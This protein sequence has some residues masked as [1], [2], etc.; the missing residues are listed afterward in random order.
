MK[1]LLYSVVLSLL[2]C[3]Q[4]FGANFYW[5]SSLAELN[6]I[7]GVSNSDKAIVMDANHNFIP[8]DHLSGEWRV[9][10]IGSKVDPQA[11]GFLPTAT[12]AV[13]REALQAAINYASPANKAIY[14]SEPGTYSVDQT[15]IIYLS[16]THIIGAGRDKVF[17]VQTG[18]DN[19]AQ[20]IFATPDVI[21]RIDNV[22]FEGFTLRG[23]ELGGQSG[24]LILAD[25]VND[26]RVE[27]M[28]FEKWS[29]MAIHINGTSEASVGLDCYNIKIKNNDFIGRSAWVPGGGVQIYTADSPEVS[30]N[31][32]DYVSR[33]I[34]FE[35]GASAT[36]V[37]N[38]AKVIMNHVS[39]GATANMSA[40]NKYFGILFASDPPSTIHGG[41]VAL[42]TFDTN[43]TDNIVGSADIF[44]D[45]AD[46]KGMVVGFNNHANG[47]GYGVIVTSATGITISNNTYTN[48]DATK[49]TYGINI[50]GLPNQ[51]TAEHN[52]FI[53][54]FV[55]DIAVSLTTGH[56]AVGLYFNIPSGTG[57]GTTWGS[58][59][60][61]VS[62]Y[63]YYGSPGLGYWMRDY[64]NESDNVLYHQTNAS[65]GVMF[66]AP[67]TD[68]TMKNTIQLYPASS[69]TVDT[70][71]NNGD[72]YI[73]NGNLKIG[74][75]PTSSPGAGSK[76]LWY[77]TSDNTVKYAP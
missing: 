2:I 10:S 75:L 69:T 45:K 58:A 43:N 13:N 50:T 59:T 67:T 57:S 14:I 27:N 20:K 31:Y 54:T 39:H 3:S 62:V 40:S 34:S 70:Y 52:K 44:I 73:E 47:N 9:S 6:A 11:F 38:N 46:T 55:T 19:T 71:L 68:G 36:F 48:T 5:K 23:T 60:D 53:G 42:N 74:S 77:D 21:A 65:G 66:R 12:A 37:L 7:T 16:N 51:V 24:H 4:V 64:I 29:N 32:F 72:V 56:G 35:M 25:Y 33:P 49:S 30:G 41:I 26:F 61:N 8:Y 76:K 63:G 15:A 17:I 18:S 22:V 28:R 1:R